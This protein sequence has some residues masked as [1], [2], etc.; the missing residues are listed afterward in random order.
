MLLAIDQPI[1]SHV[2]VIGV[3]RG[4]NLLPADLITTPSWAVYLMEIKWRNRRKKAK[5]KSITTTT[6]SFVSNDEAF[7][8]NYV[9]YVSAH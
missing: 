5:K 1:S 2:F 9:V 6:N 8:H 4:D 7:R 3:S